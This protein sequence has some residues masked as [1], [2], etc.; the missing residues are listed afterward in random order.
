MG[1][2]TPKKR[3]RPAKPDLSLREIRFAQHYAEHGCASAAYRAAGF[4]DK[5]A[6]SVHVLAWRVLRKPAVRS[7]IRQL[8]DEAC[9]AAQ[10][11]TNRLAKALANIAFA[12]RAD[13]FDDKG[14]LLPP[15]QWPPDVAAT[16][17][18]IESEDLFE[19]ISAKGQPK[20][21]ELKGH[22]RKVKTAGRLGA[23][24]LLAEWKGM[25]KDAQAEMFDQEITRLRELLE[26]VK[27]GQ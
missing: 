4:S 8:R 18:G 27:R 1:T 3:E 21:K 5:P 14:R 11:T 12:N 17:E 24:K 13:L 22:A 19:L 23:L 6:T 7:Y 25:V 15:D 10:V 26:Q 9:T 20:R 2:N 16:V